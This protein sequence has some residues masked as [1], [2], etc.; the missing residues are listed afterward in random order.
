MTM[1]K[2]PVSAS[3][4][5]VVA[6]EGGVRLDLDAFAMIEIT[7]LLREWCARLMGQ[8]ERL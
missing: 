1:E 5:L 7:Q 2:R 4:Y 3:L 8:F 6:G